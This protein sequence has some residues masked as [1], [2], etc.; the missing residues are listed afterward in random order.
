MA[1]VLLIEP[2]T[3]LARTYRQALQ[4]SGYTVDHAGSAQD[5]VNQADSQKPDVV[6]MELQI[7][8][9]DGIEFLQEFRSY[10]EW[11]DIPV[12]VNTSTAPTALAPARPALQRDLGVTDCLYKPR[13]T[14]QQL[15][16]AV[17]SRIAEAA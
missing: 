14:L 4:H 11:Q 10:P 12:I 7:A 13:T 8:V 1:H 2:D 9:H 3:A 15:I 6:V 5:A 17:K 16:S